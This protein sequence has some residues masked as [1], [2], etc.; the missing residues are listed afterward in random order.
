M[1]TPNDIT[2]QEFENIEQFLLKEMP[3]EESD[4]FALKIQNDKELQNKME[5]L[6]LIFV[7]IREAALEDK[8][9]YFH[10]GI[11]SLKKNKTPSLVR[12]LF[13][14]KWLVAASLL[15]MV[16]LG[17]LL[18]VNKT[19]GQEKLFTQYY[20]PDPGL[21]TAMG[22]TE[23]YLF[24]HAMIDYKTEDYESAI[25]TWQKLLKL[26]PANDTLNYFMGSAF[27]A[28][29]KLETAIPYFEKVTQHPDSYFL[30]DA[31]WYVG[32]ILTKQGKNTEAIPYLEKSDHKN[33]EAI[34]QKLKK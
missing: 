6:N 28:E 23:S 16:A 3:Q 14:N 10:Q 27:L 8:I 21:M 9:E 26:N 1:N 2:P 15:V 32:L 7:G 34:L 12:V 22:A 31:Y 30:K 5:S 25:E 17:A 18:F 29:N 24:D 13:M 19:T 33:K 11:S 4:A 20:K